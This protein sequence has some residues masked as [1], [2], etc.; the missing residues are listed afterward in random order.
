MQVQ[1]SSTFL[2]YIVR[3]AS[4]GEMGLAPFQRQYVWEKDDVEKMMKSILRRWP[5][6]S[7]TL[8]TPTDEERHLVR[9][10]GRMGPVAHDPDV[11]TLILDGQNR[12]S[13]LIY[14]SRLQDAAAAPEYPYSE[15]ELD[16][17]FGDEVLVADA[18]T[19]D[20]T[21]R[22]SSEQW[23]ETAAPFGFI[24]DSQIFDRKRQ[25]EVLQRIPMHGWSDA[26]IDF[27]FD[28]VAACV[29]EAQV[30][31]TTLVDATFEEAKE[32][33]M[34]ICRAGQPISEEEFEMAFSARLSDPALSA[35]GPKP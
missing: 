8:W 19:R 18:A 5:I 27:L 13:S 31:T 21:F 1:Q 17:W 11:S 35:P 6:G 10:R 16:V 30:T 25:R 24:M 22:P 7:F 15:Q 29:R 14:A 28:E 9:T 20:I 26:T 23:S 34:T 3:D 32:C 2:L 33:Y 12:L 4:R